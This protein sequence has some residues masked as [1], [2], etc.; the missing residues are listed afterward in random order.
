VDIN[1]HTVDTIE[2]YSRAIAVKAKSG[3]VLPSI[4]KA[5]EE[6]LRHKTR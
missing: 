6:M 3:E 1:P 5:V 4:V 2:E